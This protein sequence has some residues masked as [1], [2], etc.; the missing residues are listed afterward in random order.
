MASLSASDV[1]ALGSA[2]A[3]AI[4]VLFFRQLAD[5]SAAATNLFKNTVASGL[6]L[7]TMAVFGISF[8]THRSAYDWAVLAGSGVVGLAIADTLFFAGLRRL[9]ASLVAICDCAYAPTV[10]VMSALFLGESFRV[11]LLIGAPLVV[12]GLFLA[13][14][15]PHRARGVP[16]DRLGIAY[17]VLGV[18]TTAAGV[19]MA[20]RVLGSSE[21][22]E[23]TTVRLLA[24][25][26]VL[27]AYHV[28]ARSL[29][30]AL[31][32][33]RPQPA[34]RFALPGTFFGTYV[35]MILW[36]GGMRLGAA[37]RTSVL[38]QLAA[39]F[40]LILSRVLGEK[41]PRRRWLGAG[42]AVTGACVVLLY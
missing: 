18:I 26:A 41:L 14:W 39:I 38:N 30:A 32:L 11:G 23:A 10:F 8:A 7:L 13:S 27:I 35:S 42:L 2:L 3:W 34:W 28:V 24:G 22:I 5:V 12:L 20:K 15:Q 4:A 17:T 40:V 19:I 6:L 37:S 33:F 25:T 21:L 31:V 29:G 9:E 36:L 16:V 1:M